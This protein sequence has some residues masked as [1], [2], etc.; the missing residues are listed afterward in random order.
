MLLSFQRALWDMV[1]PPLRGVAIRLTE[2]LIEARFIYEHQPTEDEIQIV[3]EVETYV[4]ADFTPP[5][6]ASFKA[7]GASL[8]APREL[9]TGEEWVYLRHEAGIEA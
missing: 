1:T 9:M 7:V 6:I 8:L 2:P 3:A 4:I 5:T